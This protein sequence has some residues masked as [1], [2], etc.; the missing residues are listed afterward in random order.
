MASAVVAVLRTR[1]L[2]RAWVGFGLPGMG[3]ARAGIIEMRSGRLSR[4]L[5]DDRKAGA[6]SNVL[7]SSHVGAMLYPALGYQHLATLYVYKLR[8]K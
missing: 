4:M 8:R 6:K 1:L 5:R 2:Q 3:C 7:T